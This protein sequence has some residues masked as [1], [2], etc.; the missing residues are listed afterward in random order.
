MQHLSRRHRS[1][2][3]RTLTAIAG[4]TALA[5]FALLP[6]RLGQPIP[7]GPG[8]KCPLRLL[9]TVVAHPGPD[10]GVQQFDLARHHHLLQQ[11]HGRHV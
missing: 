8:R 10:A 3:I 5:G 2:I 9:R 6:L 11:D 1:A 7:A 4:A